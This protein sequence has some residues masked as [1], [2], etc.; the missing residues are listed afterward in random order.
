MED[1]RDF[2]RICPYC[3]IVKTNSARHCVICQRCVERYDHHCPWINNCVG[4]AN[5]NTFLGLLAVLTF[6]FSQGI[7]IAGSALFRIINKSAVTAEECSRDN[8]FWDVS[9]FIRGRHPAGEEYRKIFNIGILGTIE[10][11]FLLGFILV[12]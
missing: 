8:F 12:M 3:E 11:F 10:A 2:D 4:I 5:H 1:Q 9:C 6:D 7:Y